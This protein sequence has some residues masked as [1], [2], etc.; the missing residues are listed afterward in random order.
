MSWKE[1]KKSW[2]VFYPAVHKQWRLLS[3]G[4][5]TTITAILLR[6][7][8][9]DQI[10]HWIWITIS[11]ATLL[12]AAFLA[13]DQIR[14]D[15][16]TLIDVRDYKA[17]IDRLSEFM[18]EGNNTLLNGNT[19]ET[20]DQYRSWE[21]RWQDWH[22]RVRLFLRESFG[23]REELLFANVI[24]FESRLS[25]GTHFQFSLSTNILANELES[26]RSTIIRHAERADPWWD[27]VQHQIFKQRS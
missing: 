2:V 3:A 6:I 8:F 14:K 19:I 12:M 20:D 22:N 9:P 7:L 18:H 11:T 21:A 25:Y 16:D 23:M 4:V 15:R 26:L 24:V 17:A 5:L 13:F 27:K 10:G 1:F